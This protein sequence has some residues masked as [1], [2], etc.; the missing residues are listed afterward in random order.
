LQSR[1]ASAPPG[2]Y[3]QRLFKDPQ[4]LA[5]KVMEEAKELCLAQTKDD[6]AFEAA[7]L[8]YFALTKC[9]ASGVTLADIEQCLD[10]KAKKVTRR[11]G[12]AKPEF[13]ANPPKVNGKSHKSS[14]ERPSLADPDASC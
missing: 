3:T 13:I 6:V 4:F 14:A 2:S 10:E 8:L 7:D 12:D 11:K 1:L 9:V 5:N